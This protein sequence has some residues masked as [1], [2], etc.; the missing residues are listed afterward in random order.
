MPYYIGDVIKDERKLV[1]RT[2]EKF[3]EAGVEVR[4]NVTAEQVDVHQGV[5]HLSDGTTLSYDI[6]TLATGAV[7]LVPRI[8]GVDLEGVFVLKTLN[9]ALRMKSFL[10]HASCRKA[11]IVG[12][13]FI[14]MEMSEALKMR[15]IETQVIDLLPRPAIRWDPEFSKVIVEELL[16]H[17]VEFSPETGIVAIEQGGDFRF[18]VTTTIGESEVDLVLIAVGVKPNVQLATEAG[19]QLGK[20]GAIQVDFSQRTSQSNIYAVGDC[21]EVFHR[22]SKRWV[23]IPLGDTANKQGRVAGR[24]IGG[25]V[26][27]FP[28]VVG[29][30]AF[31]LFDLEVAATGI[32][33]EEAKK[34]GYHPV[35]TIIY[36]NAIARSM[37]GG[38]KVGVKLVADRASGKLLGAQAVG[39][40]GAVHRINV[41]SCA[42]WSNLGVDEIGYLDF[43]YAPPFSPAW[44]P[45]HIAAQELMRKM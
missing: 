6:L 35:S 29:S 38:S 32:D 9:D 24:I 27:T 3:K 37:P 19:L 14:G 45:I 8:P 7:P 16:R 4:L 36:G 39:P 33:E 23:Y 41:L 1:A 12:G 28:G 20:T 44:D 17:G 34:C 22:V 42:L 43:A 11:L 31:K 21:C 26:L 13:G 18:R 5:V 10:H 15:G 30:Q 25:G 40:T 2:P